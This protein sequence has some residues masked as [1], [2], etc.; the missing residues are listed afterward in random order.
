MEFKLPR[1]GMPQL[2]P[3]APM[4][5]MVPGV[6]LIALGVLVLFNEVLIKFLVAG[7]FLVLGG[8]L[9]L[10]ARRVQRMMR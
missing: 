2:P 7:V 9:V 10:G 8:L 4:F 5:L 1:G 3:Q 6:A